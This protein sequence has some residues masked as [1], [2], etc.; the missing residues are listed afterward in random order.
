MRIWSLASLLIMTGLLGACA[1]EPLPPSVDDYI[2]SKILLDAAMAKCGIDRAR[3]KYTAECVNAREAS[4]RIAKFE[5]AER[6]KVLEAQ[7]E[8]KRAALRRAQMAAADARRRAE[9]AAKRHEEAEYFGLFAPA[10]GEPV[11]VATEES[12]PLPDGD[13]KRPSLDAPVFSSAPAGSNLQSIRKELERRQH[14][15]P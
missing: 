3:L 4:N 1:E 9:E 5:E 14:S 7:S 6:R 10:E 15:Q 11:E 8:R 2:A 12:E 13:T